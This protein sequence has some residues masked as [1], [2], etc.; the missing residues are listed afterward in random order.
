[1]QQLYTEL[2]QLIYNTLIYASE[3]N[4]YLVLDLVEKKYMKTD[5]RGIG[6]KLKVFLNFK[7][8]SSQPKPMSSLLIGWMIALTILIIF[9][10]LRLN[11][12]L[13]F[14]WLIPVKCIVQP[15]KGTLWNKRIFH[16]YNTTKLSRV[17]K[18]EGNK[19]STAIQ[20]SKWL[21]N[22]CISCLWVTRIPGLKVCFYG[23][24]EVPFLKVSITINNNVNI[25]WLKILLIFLIHVLLV[26]W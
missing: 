10:L 7:F 2:K 8:N 24:D 23:I 19:T 4:W 21:Q 1:M 6:F 16:Q 20:R 17:I 25:F 3:Y 26:L 18:A 13:M 11:L 14:Y 12:M 22:F 15:I 5:L 9:T